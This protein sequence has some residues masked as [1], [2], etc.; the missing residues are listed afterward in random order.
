MKKESRLVAT[1]RKFIMSSNWL[2]PNQKETNWLALFITVGSI[3]RS[4][5]RIGNKYDLIRFISFFALLNPMAGETLEKRSKWFCKSN[6]WFFCICRN[7]V[8][9]SFSSSTIQSCTKFDTL[10]ARFRLW[11]SCSSIAHSYILFAVSASMEFNF[12]WALLWVA[13][14]LRAVVK[15]GMRSWGLALQRKV[16]SRI[17]FDER[18]TDKGTCF[19]MHV[20][21]WLSLYESSLT[22]LDSNSNITKLLNSF[23]SFLYGMLNASN[24]SKSVS[25]SS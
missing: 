15:D 19:P 4:F 21:V 9:K 23:C 12:V 25:L 10:S 5:T 1:P 6:K 24:F 11:L 7:C 16:G 22:Q 2:S 13:N 8:D 17:K 14:P 20:A 3:S 18:E